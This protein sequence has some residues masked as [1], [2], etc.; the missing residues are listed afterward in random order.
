MAFQIEGI[1]IIIPSLLGTSTCLGQIYM[2]CWIG[3]SIM[4]S[5]C[6]SNDENKFL[7]YLLADF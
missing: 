3:E 1:D 2:L 5:V 6:L 4:A 7:G